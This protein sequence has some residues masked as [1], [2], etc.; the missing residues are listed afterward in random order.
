MF[1]P[2]EMEGK[3]QLK[4][5]RRSLDNLG[6]IIILL[7]LGGFKCWLHKLYQLPYNWINITGEEEDLVKMQI[8]TDQYYTD[9][10]FYLLT[11]E[12]ANLI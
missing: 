7:Y 4:C 3:S 2:W 9:K 6:N 11:E 1:G 12:Q 8:L 10:G 5:V